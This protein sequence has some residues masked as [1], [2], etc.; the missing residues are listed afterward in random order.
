MIAI[1]WTSQRSMTGLFVS[2]R[3]DI[4]WGFSWW[5]LR[6]ALP[7]H[8]HGLSLTRAFPTPLPQRCH[9]LR[10]TQPPAPSKALSSQPRNTSN[11]RLTQP[12]NIPQPI[13]FWR[14][15]WGEKRNM[16]S[17]RGTS[18]LGPSPNNMSFCKYDATLNAV[19]SL[20]YFT[21]SNMGFDYLLCA[22]LNAVCVWV[23]LKRWWYLL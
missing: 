12:D 2:C 7:V 8:V 18:T 14:R 10:Q 11:N 19:S 3:A 22:R 4:A 21:L 5:Q 16:R 6:H 20:I 15:R 9:G 17:A 23:I 13:Y 1:V